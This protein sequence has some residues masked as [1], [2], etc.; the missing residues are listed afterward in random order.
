MQMV[1]NSY[2][3][4]QICGEIRSALRRGYRFGRSNAA[5]WCQNP[6]CA[7]ANIIDR[8]CHAAYT[9]HSVIFSIN[10]HKGAFR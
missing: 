3:T 9:P 6:W 4:R 2:K 7:G 5:V 8:R 1:P 10:S